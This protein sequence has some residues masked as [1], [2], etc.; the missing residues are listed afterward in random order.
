[1]RPH[2]PLEAFQLLDV[3][4][5]K[6]TM[7]QAVE[8]VNS[9]VDN[10]SNGHVVTFTNVHMVV[11]ARKD[12]QFGALLAGAGMNCPDGAPI[13]WTG[14]Y[15]HGREV[16]QVAGPDFMSIY[17]AQSVARG[18]RHFLYGGASGVAE[19]AAH[20]LRILYP[21]INIV[22]TYTPPFRPLTPEEDDA[23]CGE[24]NA[25]GADIVWVCLGCPKQEKWMFDHRFRLKTKVLLGVGQAIDI[26]AGKRERAPAVIRHAGLEWLYRLLREPKR[27]WK[28]YLETNFLFIIWIVYAKIFSRNNT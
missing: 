21:G 14:R 26:I 2:L 27:L 11:E 20:K 25:S 17:C 28:R 19:I 9:W 6:I 23:V 12:P 3:P 10:S 4:V 5:A 18:D 15:R 24:I 13:F 1:M 8:Q 7:L 16:E 22:G